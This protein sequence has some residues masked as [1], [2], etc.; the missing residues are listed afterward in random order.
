[1][2]LRGR[3]APALP[4]VDKATGKATECFE[5]DARRTRP[6]WAWLCCLW[7]AMAACLVLRS[8]APVDSFARLGHAAIDGPV[9]TS[10]RGHAHDPVREP[11][12]APV[13]TSESEEQVADDGDFDRDAYSVVHRGQLQQLTRSGHEQVA[14]LRDPCVA[15]RHNRGPPVG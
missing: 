7:G 2:I 14:L 1:M 3:G 9:I 10:D 8:A 5:V 15:Q 4:S 11:P 12:G 13:E 6:G